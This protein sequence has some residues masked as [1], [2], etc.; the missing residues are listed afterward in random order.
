MLLT[1]LSTTYGLTSSNLQY[2]LIFSFIT[3]FIVYVY[4]GGKAQLH[5]LSM[6]DYIPF[7]IFLSWLYGLVLGSF[8]GV[9]SGN[10]LRNFFGM[11]IY[12]FY[13]FLL[14]TRPSR[15][16]IFNVIVA[17]AVFNIVYALIYFVRY[18]F[19][20]GMA[21]QDIDF[22]GGLSA[23]FRSYYS[24]GV[25][26]LG[27]VLAV[28]IVSM[29][30]RSIIPVCRNLN[31]V[32]LFF[33]SLFCVFIMVG[34]TASKGF[35][36]SVVF[37]VFFL[38]SAFLCRSIFTKKQYVF[39]WA[40][41]I[42]AVLFCA[43]IVTST[44][45]GEQI[46]YSLSSQESSNSVRN[47]QRERL[48]DE[49][50]FFGSGLGARLDS[51]YQRDDRGY[52]FE[53]TY[54]NIIHKLGVVSIIPFSAFIFTLIW[55]WMNL[56]VGKDMLFSSISGGLLIY[57]IPS[58]GNPMLFSPFCVVMHC[59]ALY[60]LREGNRKQVTPIYYQKELD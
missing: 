55:V 26:I 44:P 53:L 36:L 30:E 41:S 2:L 28:C 13:Y 10:I 16:S 49:F 6:P 51:G 7:A 1:L 38:S 46:K 4:M 58:Y 20:G 43:F 23:I 47:E 52:G 40:I 14:L 27:P 15:R 45:V 24:I 12:L 59:L 25:L 56:F 31:R 17:A 18:W 3:I 33:V 48:S 50:S 57:L 21:A 9:E 54:E 8:N 29:F 42:L 60:L 5:K 22:D 32:I 11:S 39:G 35:A 37:L 34:T 19:L